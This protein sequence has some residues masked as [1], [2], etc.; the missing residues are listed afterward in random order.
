MSNPTFAPPTLYEALF[1]AKTY[2]DRRL[3]ELAKEQDVGALTGATILVAKE[4]Q[5]A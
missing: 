3:K 2:M 5:R 1:G 4:A